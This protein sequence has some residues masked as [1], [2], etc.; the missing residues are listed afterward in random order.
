VRRE[1]RAA[2]HD[3][4]HVTAQPL[5]HLQRRWARCTYDTHVVAA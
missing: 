1:R 4:L 2:A 3:E 5:L